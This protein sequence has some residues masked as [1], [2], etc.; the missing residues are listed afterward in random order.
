[1][2][3]WQW[4][5]LVETFVTEGAFRLRNKPIQFTFT[6]K[7]TI[8]LGYGT[9]VSKIRRVVLSV[10]LIIHTLWVGDKEGYRV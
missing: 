6:A 10:C 8:F 3:R 5:I 4:L 1:M 2:R 7:L 9:V